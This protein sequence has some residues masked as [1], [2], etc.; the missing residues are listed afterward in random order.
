M[1]PRVGAGSYLLLM[2]A[3]VNAWCLAMIALYYWGIVPKVV[4]GTVVDYG[5]WVVAAPVG[6][7]FFYLSR[8]RLRDL[9]CPGAGRGCWRFRSLG[10]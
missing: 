5:A 2:S 8:R 6:Y 9:N 10:C 7:L 4:S 3:A 1:G